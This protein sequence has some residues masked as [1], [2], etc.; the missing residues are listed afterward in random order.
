MGIGWIFLILLV[1]FAVN[2]IGLI[3]ERIVTQIS[4]GSE[5]GFANEGS[6]STWLTNTELYDSF[7][8]SVYDQLCKPLTRNQTE[9]ALILHEWTKR[10]EEKHTFRVLDI[11]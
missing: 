7:Y 10:G 6:G 8:A 4:T 1:L 11:G 2:Y 9:A 3:N 5:E